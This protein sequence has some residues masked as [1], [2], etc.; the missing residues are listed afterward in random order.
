MLDW[1]LRLVMLLAVPCAVALLTFSK[2]L[3]ATLYHYGAFTDHDV[4]QTTTALMGYGAGL[5]GLV[6]IKVLAPRLLR[7]PGHPH[8]VRIAIAVLVVTQ[9]LNMALVPLFKH[10][11]LALSICCSC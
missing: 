5:L 10:A 7:Q 6:A 2:P 9:L 4:Q 11:G 3:V 1:G 8:A